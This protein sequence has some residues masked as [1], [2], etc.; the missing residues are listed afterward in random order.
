MRI[1]INKEEKMK[2]VLREKGTAFKHYLIL[3]VDTVTVM[4]DNTHKLSYNISYTNV[5]EDAT[6]FS[7]IDAVY[8]MV[9]GKI[10]PF[11]WDV[12][13]LEI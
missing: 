8:E 13:V 9:A 5:I 4:E 2:Y 6:K 11:K 7:C 12:E 10:N 3:N 1:I